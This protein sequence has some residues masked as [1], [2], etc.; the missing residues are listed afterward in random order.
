[1]VGEIGFTAPWASI[2]ESE[3]YFMKQ[4]AAIFLLHLWFFAFL[5]GISWTLFGDMSERTYR[6]RMNSV[7]SSFL[8]PGFFAN[9]RYWT[10]FSKAMALIMIPMVLL[11]YYHG[12][13][14]LLEN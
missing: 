13:K 10:W 9:L 4:I 5:G 8:M 11:V 2:T 1:M 14:S 12:M 7:F 6:Q 3:N